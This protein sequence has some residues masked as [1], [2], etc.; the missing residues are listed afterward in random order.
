MK[1]AFVG[2]GSLGFTRTLVIDM[3][4]WEAMQ[5]AT[6]SLIDVDE[7]RLDYARRAVNR[8]VQ[9]GKY[10]AKVEA[11]LDR[12][13]GLRDADIVVATILAHGVDGFRPEIEIPMKYRSEERRVGKSV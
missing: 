8:I 1:I 13:E 7:T 6:L 2:A 9:V 3:L 10:P 11:T 12:A 5:D 4:S